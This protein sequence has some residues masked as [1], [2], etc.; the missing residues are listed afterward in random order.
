MPVK[1]EILSIVIDMKPKKRSNN[2]GQKTLNSITELNVM[3]LF[4]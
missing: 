4:A 1:R 3:S 2:L